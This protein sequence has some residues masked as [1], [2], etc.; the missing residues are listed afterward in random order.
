MVK[1]G[2]AQGSPATVEKEHREPCPLPA[3]LPVIVLY[4]PAGHGAS[5]A[6]FSAA[7]IDVAG[8]KG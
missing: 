5:F 4:G 3:D 1:E 6:F 8:K 2:R 7:A